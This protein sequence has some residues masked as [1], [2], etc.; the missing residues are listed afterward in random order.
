MK[1]FSSILS[2]SILLVGTSGWLLAEEETSASETSALF[3]VTRQDHQGNVH[4]IAASSRKAVRVFVFM[5]GE[6][7]VSRTYFPVLNELYREWGKNEKDI[8]LLGIWADVTQT[9]QDVAGMAKEFS[10]EFPILLDRDASL[11]KAL[12]PT[13]V[14]E[15]FV[16]DHHGEI[17]YR[18]RI[19]DRFLKLG[20]RKPEATENTL[21]QAVEKVAAGLP[22]LVPRTKPVGCYYELPPTPSLEEATLTFN[23]DIAPILNA[24]CV[25]C[26]R[27]GEV[28]PFTLTS[29]M[30]AAKRARQIARVVDT[31]LMPPWKAAQVHGEFEGQR[32]LTDREIETLKAWAKSD[33]AEGDPADLPPTPTF[34]SDWILGEPDLVLEMQEDFEVPAG[35]ADIF[36]N[37]VIPYEIPEDKLVAAVQF[38]PGDASVVHHSIL[39]L[40]N[41]GKA[42]AKDAAAPGPGYSTF[43]G[44]GFVPSGSIGGWSPGKRPHPLPNGL[45]RKMQKGADLVMQIHYHPSGK[46]TKD[47]SKVGIYFVDN[48][49]NEAFAIWTSSFDLDIPPGEEHYKAT[50][51]YK[52]PAEV[53][54]LSCIPH[55]HLLGQQ[56]KATA[57]LPDG[58][59]KVLIDVPQWDFNWQDEYMLAEPMQLPA[60]TRIK[61]TASY[62]NSEN[63]PTNPSSPPQRVTFGEETT[64]EM[65]YCFFLVAAKEKSTIPVVLGDVFTQEVLRRSAHRLKMGR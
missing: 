65:L 36:R 30:D 40:D 7:P 26:H 64:D 20:S 28:G 52:L 2:V 51:S 60:G 39:Y 37:F 53:T 11:G 54:L 17:G 16:L 3:N 48:P 46:A 10:I 15:V 23:R 42:R 8:Q 14:P 58:T 27:E 41:S 18:G 57:Y 13:T 32:T 56:M 47:R 35:G 50:A 12:A 63:N 33:R 59:S 62:D 24:N 44:P 49:K 31:K 22:V 38:K 4:Q 45:G 5:T 19:D 55:M 25:V 34:A 9:P 43:G 1:L 6:C 29:Y 61:V 21:Q